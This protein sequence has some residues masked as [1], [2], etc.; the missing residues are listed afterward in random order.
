MKHRRQASPASR[1]KTPSRRRIERI[2]YGV[3][4]LAVLAV[5]VLATDAHR[6]LVPG[7]SAEAAAY[8]PA[9]HVPKDPWLQRAYLIEARHRMVYSRGWE[10]ANGS[11]GAAYLYRATGDSSL[12]HFYTVEQNLLDLFNGTWVDDRAWC[13]LAELEWWDVTGRTNRLWVE[14]AKRRY[15]EARAEGR[16]SKHEGFWTWYNWPPGADVRDQIFTNSNMNQMV[17]VACGLYEATGEKEFLD[18]ALKVWNGDG[19][20]PGIEQR[21]YRGDGVWQG[22]DGR[23]A[24]GKEI[25]WHG[26]EYC[27]IMAALYRVTGEKKYKEMIVATA[28]RIMDPANGWVDATDYFQIHMDGNGAFVHYLLDAYAVAPD[29]LADLLPKIE[30]MLTHVWTNHGGRSRVVLHRDADH[31]IRNGWNPNGG[32]DGYGVDDLGTT[33]AQSQALRAFGVYAY[34]RTTS[35]R[36]TEAGPR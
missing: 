2:M 16:L 1:E 12:L 13:A 5:I 23:A 30:R 10:G 19:V 24:F 32:E 15:L 14:S 11:I 20:T 4:A 26:T 9:R 7:S 36:T 31:A 33:H 25:P 22:R 27:S 17:N 35:S 34:Y 3:A 28:R 21:Y 18:D 29:E 8:V 6:L